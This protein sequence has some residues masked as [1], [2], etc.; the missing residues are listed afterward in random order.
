VNPAQAA[1]LQ[2]R[3]SA[4]F[5]GSTVVVTPDSDGAHI[6]LEHQNGFHVRVTTGDQPGTVLRALLGRDLR[7]IDGEA[8]GTA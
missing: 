4:R 5:A 8:E 6:F 7:V 3:L 1:R 2:G